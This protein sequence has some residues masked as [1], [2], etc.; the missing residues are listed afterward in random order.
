MK[1]E[2]LRALDE[3]L[4]LP[5]GTLQGEEKLEDLENWNSLSVISF[6]AL[7]DQ[8]TG[9]KIQVKQIG[10]CESVA[11]LLRLAEVKA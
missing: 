6:I 4:E 9:A 10:N 1:T 3:I 7:A 11:D 8:K 5:A 2:F